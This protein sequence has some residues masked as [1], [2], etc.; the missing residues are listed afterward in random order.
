MIINKEKNFVSAVVYVHNNEGQIKGFLD[1]ILSVLGENFEKY[2]IICVNDASED[3]SAAAIK[4][5][6]DRFGDTVVSIIN[7]GFFQ[8]REMAMNAGV[9][10]SIGDFVFEFDSLEQ[11]Y[12]L[13]LIMQV[14]RHSLKGGFDIVSAAPERIK[15]R[16][17][18][19]YYSFFNLFS[20]YHLKMRPESFRILSRRSINRVRALTVT[21]PYR[22]AVYANCGLKMDCL[23][24]SPKAMDRRAKDKAISKYRSALALDTLIL[25][26]DIA[27][28]FVNVMIFATLISTFAL[29]GY[30]LF[31]AFGRKEPVVWWMMMSFLLSLGFCALFTCMA[32][33]IKYLSIIEGLVFKRQRYVIESIEKIAQ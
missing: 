9:D 18:R 6:A 14:Y 25:F 10:L 15:R 29:A 32:T 33:I 11:D 16:S 23:V 1:Q 27:G 17:V 8:G 20:K 5:M 24:Y 4:Q 30:M 21:V 22:K 31:V 3:D 26:T 28:W 7:M 2:E 19:W 12:E 13:D